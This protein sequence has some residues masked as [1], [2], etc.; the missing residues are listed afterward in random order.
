MTT[1]AAV[2]ISTHLRGQPDL[3]ALFLENVAG[4]V[5]LLVFLRDHGFRPRNLRLQKRDIAAKVLDRIGCEVL[6]LRRLLARFEI[7]NFHGL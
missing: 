1:Y 3:G 7:V 4:C 2:I 5:Q 6:W